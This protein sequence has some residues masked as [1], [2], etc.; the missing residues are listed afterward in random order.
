MP[1]NEGLCCHLNDIEHFT[2]MNKRYPSQSLDL[3]G[4]YKSS[5]LE[6]FLTYRLYRPIMGKQMSTRKIYESM[7]LALKDDTFIKYFPISLDSII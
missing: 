7:N 6:S 1:S 3:K 2:D 4:T 5:G